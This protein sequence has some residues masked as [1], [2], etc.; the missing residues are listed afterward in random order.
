MGTMDLGKITIL[1]NPS[2]P[3]I[4]IKIESPC[5]KQRPSF[6]LSVNLMQMAA[7]KPTQAA[8]GLLRAI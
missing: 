8:V 1:E 5:A 7:E 3:T 4:E 6:L 2:N